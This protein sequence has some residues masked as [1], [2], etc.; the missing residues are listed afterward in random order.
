[1]LVKKD[2]DTYLAKINGHEI[3][4]HVKTVVIRNFQLALGGYIFNYL[5]SIISINDTIE[6]AHSHLAAIYTAIKELG[7]DT[8]LGIS[9][10]DHVIAC[11]NLFLGPKRTKVDLLDIVNT[12]ETTFALAHYIT[13]PSE[14]DAAEDMRVLVSGGFIHNL[15]FHADVYI[16]LGIIPCDVVYYEHRQPSISHGILTKNH[17]FR[18]GSIVFNG[19]GKRFLRYGSEND[20][21]IFLL[22]PVVS[23]TDIIKLVKDEVIALRTPYLYGA[24]IKAIDARLGIFTQDEIRAFANVLLA[25]VVPMGPSR[26]ILKFMYLLFWNMKNGHAL[27]RYFVKHVVSERHEYEGDVRLIMNEYY[28]F[29]NNQDPMDPLCVLL[30]IVEPHEHEFISIVESIVL[31]YMDDYTSSYDDMVSYTKIK[32]HIPAVKYRIENSF[33]FVFGCAIKKGDDALL[34]LRRVGLEVYRELSNDFPIPNYNGTLHWSVEEQINPYSSNATV[35]G[36]GVFDSPEWK[37]HGFTDIME[38]N[39]YV[40]RDI[41]YFKEKL[42]KYLII[43]TAN[44]S[45][46]P[47]K[48]LGASKDSEV[49]VLKMAR[50]D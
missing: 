30:D 11:L 34:P 3:P 49:H 31:A 44:D 15:G 8:F 21:R 42:L 12:Y 26:C 25:L 4:E 1:M 6:A 20:I 35:P 46:D 13:A 23:P 7:L 5:D 43:P 19:I 18:I 50:N 39:N 2:T 27:V 38:G 37:K 16:A 10:I 24:A 33:E 17:Y 9:Q 32:K 41:N 28:V 22:N 45:F 47:M 36:S 40:K 29:L 14:N 48:R